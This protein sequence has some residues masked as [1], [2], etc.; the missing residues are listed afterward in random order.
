MTQFV[1]DEQVKNPTYQ[2]A[3][4]LVIVKRRA[5][6]ES[7]FAF[8]KHAGRWTNQAGP[9]YESILAYW[10]NMVGAIELLLKVLADDWKDG[11]T[12]YGHNVGRMY[13]VVFGRK[14]ADPAF[15]HSL[16]TAIMDQK[17][18]FEPDPGIANRIPD[19]EQ[20]WD[21]LTT[22]FYGRQPIYICHIDKEVSLDRQCVEFFRDYI[23][24]FIP[25]G[26]HSHT[27]QSKEQIL[28]D[29]QFQ[30]ERLAEQIARLESCQL[31]EQEFAEREWEQHVERVHQRIRSIQLGLHEKYVAG[32]RKMAFFAGGFASVSQD[33]LG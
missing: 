9:R 29:L 18:L 23:Q 33:F 24:R 13:E 27:R 7:I 25:E 22:M 28:Q 20:L 10:S 15:M 1:G 5:A 16:K 14:H 3:I 4:C 6:K 8:L 19:L 11:E 2:E 32:E 17:F 12:E 31:S 30:H 21:E 26:E